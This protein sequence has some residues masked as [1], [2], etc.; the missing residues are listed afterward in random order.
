MKKYIRINYVDAEPMTRG[1]Y[2]AYRGWTL[3]ADERAED[4]GYIIYYRK[5]LP[6][7]YVS[8]CPKRQFDEV[9]TPVEG[10]TF[11]CVKDATEEAVNRFL[12]D[13]WPED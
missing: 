6:D 13:G 12:N 3:P 7:E 4:E 5:G 8:W 10:D 9:S 2:N 11:V 1:E